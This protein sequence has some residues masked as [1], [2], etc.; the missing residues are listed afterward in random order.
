MWEGVCGSCGTKQDALI[1]EAKEVLQRKHDEAERF[2]N[3][4][5]FDDAL[6]AAS[7]IGEQNDL[8]L[9]QFAAWHEEFSGRLESSRTSEHT[10]LGELLQEALAH[11]QA[12]DYE[13]GLQTL[14]QVAPSLKQTPVTGNEDTADVLTERLT[15]KQSRLKELETTVR[16]RVS[17]RE[18]TGLLPFV[19]EL[20]VLKPDR[21]EV[22]KLKAQ[23]EKRE[24]DLLAAQSAAV[25]QTEARNQQIISQAQTHIQL[26]QFD[27]AIQILGTIAPEYQTFT[28]TG[29]SQQANQLSVQRRGL[30]SDVPVALSNNDYQ[31]AIKNIS[32]YLSEIVKARIQDPQLQQMLDLAQGKASVFRRKKQLVTL[33]IAAACVVVMLISGVVIKIS[34][35]TKAVEIAITNL[36]WETALELDPDNAEGLRMK[37]AAEKALKERAARQM[38]AAEK[39]RAVTAALVKRD[40]KAVLAIDPNNV[41]GLRIKASEEKATAVTAAIAKGDWKTV[42]ALSPENSEVLR[43]KATE[44]KAIAV[45]AALAKGDWNTALALDPNNSEGLEMAA[46]AA[47]KDAMEKAAAEIQAR[48]PTTYPIGMALIGREKEMKREL[49]ASYGGTET[50]ESAVIR[51]LEWLKRNQQRDGMWSLTGNYTLGGPTENRAAATAMALLAFQGHGSTHKS[52]PYQS[53]VARGWNG[54]IKKQDAEGN[55]FSTGGH[56]HRLYTHAQATIALCELYGMTKDETLKAPA[57]K[58]LSYCFASQSPQGGWRYAPGGASDTSVTGWFVMALQTGRMAG[59]TVPDVNLNRISGYLDTATTDDGTRYAYM[60]GQSDTLS[61]T[62][63]GLLCRQYLGWKQSDPRLVRGLDYL[64]DNPI[65]F[66]DMDVYYWYYCTQAMHHM[67]GEHWAKWNSVMRRSIPAEQLKT[68]NESGSWGPDLD[69]HG[70]LGGRLY[71]TCLCIYML[72]AYYRHLPIYQHSKKDQLSPEF[73]GKLEYERAL[74]L[75]QSA[76]LIGNGDERDK[77]FAIAQQFLEKIAQESQDAELK[78][79]ASNQL[80]NLLFQRANLILFE[81]NQDENKAVRDDLLGQARTLLQRAREI[82]VALGTQLNTELDVIP[83]TLD[84]KTQQPQIDRRQSLYGNY[85]QVLITATKLLEEIGKTY[86]PGTAEHTSAFEKALPE[87]DEIAIK[88]RNKGAGLIALIGQGRCYL[89][90]DDTKRSMSYLKQVVDQRETPG[91]RNIVTLAMPLYIETLSHESV[92]QIKQALAIGV[93]WN[94][95][96]RP[97]ETSN[98]EWHAFQLELARTYIKK[99]QALEKKNPEDPESRKAYVAARKLTQEVLKYPG[100]YKSVARDLIA[101]LNF[102]E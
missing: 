47:D 90:I 89:A 46:A 53:V 59:L 57:E 87:Y 102:L 101:S 10:R 31:V 7:E 35:D 96:I 38:A 56:H 81:A 54:L 85:L 66:A 95:D 18:I 17:K 16:E 27:E 73:Q 30:V 69:R 28:T 2:L 75:I 58:A 41:D 25:K 45:T 86:D 97:N 94:A 40:W 6:K 34:N 98:I 5:K 83:E 100:Q 20:L 67:G 65:S 11:E 72:E 71:S 3:E 50:T 64:G 82:Y 14:T 91:F 68:G 13:A 42:L 84:P 39:A 26:L 24:A 29:L 37:S 55:F 76:R 21:P 70:H 92:N 4:L 43:I 44:E 99:A 32:L 78:I 1:E 61:M 9:Q 8:R 12:Y 60:P 74:V 49:L 51:G 88:Y 77:Q 52:G 33:G 48:I 62:A 93:E 79:L 63:E 15:T 23:L 19:D 22:Q 80:G 36:D